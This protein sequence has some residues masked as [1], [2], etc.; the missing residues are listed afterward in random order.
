M[1]KGLPAPCHAPAAR[2]SLLLV[3]LLLDDHI[4]RCV[5]ELPTECNRLGGAA[6]S[7]AARFCHAHASARHHA[8]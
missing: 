3:V 8:A 7:G 5:N 6:S 1:P 2:T 4:R